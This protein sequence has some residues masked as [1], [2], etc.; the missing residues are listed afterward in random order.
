M[1]F[2]YGDAAKHIVLVHPTLRRTKFGQTFRPSADGPCRATSIFCQIIQYNEALSDLLRMKWDHFRN[3][4]HCAM[5]YY[6]TSPLL[7]SSQ[8]LPAPPN[9]NLSFATKF[10]GLETIHPT[11]LITTTCLTMEP[12]VWICMGI[13][14]TICKWA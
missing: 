4:N 13:K 11:L 2:V 12:G 6:A 3:H 5:L 7:R 9:F 10:R 14:K 8:M 1:L